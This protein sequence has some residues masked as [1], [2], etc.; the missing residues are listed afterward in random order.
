MFDEFILAQMPDSKEKTWLIRMA[1]RATPYLEAMPN[2]TRDTC[3]ERKHRRKATE[4]FF[5]PIA[6]SAE[7]GRYVAIGSHGVTISRQRYTQK[8]AF[9]KFFGRYFHRKT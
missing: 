4:S 8:V 5:Q 9:V 6:E 1:A 2:G 7:K 3:N